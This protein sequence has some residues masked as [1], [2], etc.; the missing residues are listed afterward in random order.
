MVDV[1]PLVPGHDGYLLSSWFCWKGCLTHHLTPSEPSDGLRKIYGVNWNDLEIVFMTLRYAD[2]LWHPQFFSAITF[3]LLV[4]SG[5]RTRV[6]GPCRDS[7][8][9][10]GF[11]EK[12]W[13]G[14]GGRRLCSRCNRACSRAD[15]STTPFIMQVSPF[16]AVLMSLF[17]NVDVEFLYVCYDFGAPCSQW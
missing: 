4:C 3:G 11:H 14:E 8:Q 7:G 6:R 12:L 10:C 17:P 1:W 13:S 2:K 16:K 15:R 5:P 9:S